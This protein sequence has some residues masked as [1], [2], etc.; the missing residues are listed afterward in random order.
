MSTRHPIIA[1]TGSSGAG[2][3]TVMKSFA[4]IFRREGISPQVIEGDSFHRFDRGEMRERVRRADTGEGPPISHFGP[5]SNLLADLAGT[6]EEYGRSGS[7]R[8]RRYI[9]DEG[10]ARELGGDPGTF[11]AWQPMVA[12]SDLLFYE[13]L[14]G[15]YVGPEADVARHVDLLVGVVPI[16]NLEWIQKLHRDQYIRGYSQTAVVD[17]ILRRMPDYVNHICPQFSRTH[18]NF[19]RVP[20]VD[21]SNP[22][23]AKDIPGADESMVV[24]RFANPKGIDFGYLLSMLHDSWMSR[25]NNIVVPGGKMGLAMQLIFTPMILRLMDQRRRAQ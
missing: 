3:S 17:T 12:A 19:Q 18:V 7:G 9:H 11:T 20:T 6:F 15:A 5:E 24:I 14:H 8:V 25:P 1:V 2:T 22:F 10:E 13:G 4:H 16:I 21:T 23:I